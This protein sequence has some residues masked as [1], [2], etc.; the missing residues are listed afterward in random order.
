MRAI[1]ICTVII[2]AIVDAPGAPSPAPLSPR[3]EQAT[4]RLLP[5]FKIEL[6]ACE[7]DIV[8]PV[9]MAFDERGRMFVVEMR[10]YPNGGVATGQQTGGRVRCLEDRDGDGYFETATTYIDGLR[11]PTG[12]TPWHGGIL[13]GNAPDILYCDDA[14]HRRVLYTGFDLA[15]IQQ[16]VNSLQ[17]G[18]DNWVYGCAGNKGGEI[19]S[20]EK[21]VMPPISLHGRGIRIRP[22]EPGSLQPTSGGG[23]YGL[24][25]DAF[26]NWFTATN[27]QHLRHIVLPDEALAR[28]PYLAVSAITHDIPDHGAACSVFRI[29]PFEAWRVERT[30]RRVADQKFANWPSEE[31]V[32]GGFITSGCS[33]L[34]YSADR[35]PPEFRGNSFVCD[36][37]NNVIHRDKLE[38]AG[39]TFVARRADAG[40]EFLAS[41]DNWFRPVWLTLGP[42]A[43]IYVLDFYREVIETPLSL[44]DDIKKKLN[45]ESRGRGRIWRIA[46]DDGR[47]IGRTDLSKLSSA[48]LA[49]LLTHPNF[50]QRLTAQR[51]IVER[52][53]KSAAMHLEGLVRTGKSAETRVHALRTLDGIQALTEELLVA[54][55]GDSSAAVR[56]HAVALAAT[57]IERPSPLRSAAVCA[58]RDGDI[59]VRFQ[60]AL[61]ASRLDADTAAEMLTA[62]LLRDGGDPWSQSAALSSSAGCAPFLLTSLSRDSRFFDKSFRGSLLARLAT[63]IGA[64]G[65]GVDLAPIFRTLA[66]GRP[67]DSWKLVV[68]EGLGQG[69]RNSGAPL[70]AMWNNPTPELAATRPI[71][72]Q[73]ARISGD[74]RQR[75]S[76]RLDGLRLLAYS[77]FEVAAKPIEQAL[78]PDNSPE[79]TSAAL[80]AVGAHDRREVAAMILRHWDGFGPSQRRAAIETLCSRPMWLTDLFDAIESKQLGAAQIEPSRRDLLRKHPDAALRRRA[81]A[82]L[83]LSGSADRAAVVASHRDVLSMPGDPQRGAA[84]FRSVCASCHRLDDFGHDVGPNLRSAL[85]NKT[86]EALLIDILDPN[87]EVDPRYVVYQAATRNG[88][89]ITGILSV[90]TAASVTLRRADQAED[91]VLRSQL[92]SLSATA[93]SLMPE[94]IEKQ[95]SK[96]EL[97]DLLA[98]LLAGGRKGP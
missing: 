58:A 14:G 46:P 77:P 89:V 98:Y 78:S 5:G 80:A 56:E 96:Q 97:A 8:D 67:D 87:R 22:D 86:A 84:V 52:Q 23:Q 6:V 9:A 26:G 83:T 81:I 34:I 49:A 28:N 44:P 10:G 88:R 37:A 16:L 50:W 13:V 59:R 36:P 47:K 38:P 20:S 90:E 2:A 71:F 18:L 35:F 4:F 39:V 85:G 92:E 54:A 30:T 53:D 57:R 29:S 69:L 11:F 32:P 45:L 75:L 1:V 51:I 76:D 7:P 41:T 19:R 42:D 66:E 95:I 82:L 40:C 70:N 68:L 93:A 27:S 79:M 64:K 12:V 25:A 61:A 55:L 3:E 62:I 15:N 31:K 72:E 74:S 91:T 48:E 94:G 17:F 21:P 63:I 60:A 24:A 33:P 73:S 65:N 43:A